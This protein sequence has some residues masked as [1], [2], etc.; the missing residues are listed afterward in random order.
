MEGFEN[1]IRINPNELDVAAIEQSELF[2]EYSQ[3]AVEARSDVDRAK[4]QLETI[5]NDLNTDV[6]E[7]PAKYHMAKTTEAAITAKVKT[8]NAYLDA[9]KEFLK[10]QETHGIMDAAM[11]AMEHRKRMIE[12]LTTLHGQQ[13]FAGPKT[14]RNLEKAYSKRMEERSERVNK[15]QKKNVRKR[16]KTRADEENK[17][18]MD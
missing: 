8:H 17:D 11:R 3:K 18:D 5:E 2:F 12:I 1:D 10:A 13:Y 6:R 4:L 14:P 16:K 7:N 15:I 9:R